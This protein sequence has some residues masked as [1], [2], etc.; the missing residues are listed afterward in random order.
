MGGQRILVDR[1]YVLIYFKYMEKGPHTRINLISPEEPSMEKEKIIMKTFA[2]V[3]R[4]TAEI[5]ARK[6]AKKKAR[7][8]EW[9]ERKRA[10]EELV[11]NEELRRDV[12][13]ALGEM[14][15][16]DIKDKKILKEGEKSMAKSIWNIL[17]A[18]PFIRSANKLDRRWKNAKATLTE[19]FSAKTLGDLFKKIG[20]ETLK[21]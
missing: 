19:P 10:F 18:T 21:M 16:G 17:W 13:R 12:G 8:L 5:R 6:E 2:N 3:G 20:S 9:A 7:H 1:F 15:P 4:Y 14:Y 11:K